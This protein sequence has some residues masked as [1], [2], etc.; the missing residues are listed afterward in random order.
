MESATV[1]NVNANPNSV[2]RHANARVYKVIALRPTTKNRKR[3]KYVRDTA[4]ASVISASVIRVASEI[5]AKA[6]RGMRL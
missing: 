3:I 1:A 5:S 2:A 4:H 6:L